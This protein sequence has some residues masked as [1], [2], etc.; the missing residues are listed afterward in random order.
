MRQALYEYEVSMCR[1][2]ALA[3]LNGSQ[4]KPRTKAQKLPL[5]ESELCHYFPTPR[6][7]FRSK[8][9]ENKPLYLTQD[10]SV[11]EEEDDDESTAST[12]TISLIRLRFVV[13][14]ILGWQE[15]SR[16]TQSKIQSF[17]ARTMLL[18]DSHGHVAGDRQ[19]FYGCSRETL[20]FLMSYNSDLPL[21]IDDYKHMLRALQSSQ[22]D[23]LML[24]CLVVSSGSPM[25]KL[26]TLDEFHAVSFQEKVC[27]ND[28][29][30]GDIDKASYRYLF[31][32]FSS[33]LVSTV[34]ASSLHSLQIV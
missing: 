13:A 15:A 33:L 1:A 28:R 7:S 3:N 19:S 17:L 26:D 30:L 4:K 32:A 18:Y 23:D 12:S 11:D 16:A 8:Y 24:A 20:D 14:S 5:D 29:I 2:R 22:L 9:K 10:D 31:I 21:I 27:W 25:E 34:S 6:F